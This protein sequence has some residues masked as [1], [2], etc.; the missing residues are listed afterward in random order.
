MDE[1]V[2][3]Q[4][5]RPSENPSDGE[6]FPAVLPDL[7]YA[8]NMDEMETLHN[9]QDGRIIPYRSVEHAR[10]TLREQ[11][12][13]QELTSGQSFSG[14]IVKILQEV[15]ARGAGPQPNRQRKCARSK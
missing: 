7:Y 8:I 2:D 3:I 12:E 1:E 14:A 13:V 10:Q 5:T 15:E 6:L 9:G 11:A 4:I